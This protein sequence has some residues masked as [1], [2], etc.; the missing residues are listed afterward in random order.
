MI[1][2]FSNNRYN[3]TVPVSSDADFGPTYW[4]AGLSEPGKYTFKTAIYNATE[5]VPFSIALEGIAEGAKGTLSVLSA[6][7]GLSSNTL[8]DG[9][10]S[11]VVKKSITELT[12][13]AGGVFTFTLENYNVAVLTT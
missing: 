3:A 12:A 7:D 5:S 1:D 4:V 10:V 13:G 6:P 9:V 2:L 11:D 8:I